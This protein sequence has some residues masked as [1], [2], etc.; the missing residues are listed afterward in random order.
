MCPI[1]EPN[2]I[3]RNV[4]VIFHKINT[5]IHKVKDIRYHEKSTNILKFVILTE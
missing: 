3:Y 4:K 5:V 2:N 1:E